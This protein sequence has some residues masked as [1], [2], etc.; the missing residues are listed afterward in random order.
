VKYMGKRCISINCPYL[1]ADGSCLLPKEELLTKCPA[2]EKTSR[3]EKDTWMTEVR[4]VKTNGNPSKR[5]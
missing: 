3:E 5:N 1:S 4:F 2:R